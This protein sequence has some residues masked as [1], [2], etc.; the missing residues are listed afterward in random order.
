MSV[1]ARAVRL[2]VACGVAAALAPGVAWAQSRPPL[3]TAG[4]NG[5]ALQ[6]R[7]CSPLPCDGLSVLGTGKT[8]VP[9]TPTWS[10]D[11]RPVAYIRTF[12]GAFCYN[13]RG[14][15]AEWYDR[16]DDGVPPKDLDKNGVPD[17]FDWLL[18][19][20]DAHYLDGW[21][22]IVLLLPAGMVVK[23]EFSSSQWWAMP[24]WKRAGFEAHVK[25]WIAAHPEASV[26]LYLNFMI[27]NPCDL[28]Q[29][30][31]AFRRITQVDP[32]AIGYT[33]ECVPGLVYVHPCYG[34][35]TYRIPDPRVPEDVC[36]FS[37]NIRPWMSVGAREFWFDAA[38]YQTRKQSFVELA[39]SPDY[40]GKAKFGGE[41]VPYKGPGEYDETYVAKTP[42][43]GTTDWIDKQDP[44]GAWT[45]P[46]AKSEVGLGLMRPMEL[47]EMFDAVGRGYV[48]WLYNAA[49]EEGERAK[50][51]Y[52]FGHL[53]DGADF[54]GNGY[55]DAGDRALFTSHWNAYHGLTG[56]RFN[57][58]HGDM[59]DDHKVDD[60]DKTLFNTY[61]T[62]SVESEPVALDLGGPDADAAMP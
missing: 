48:I 4:R 22:R 26:G 20:L 45:F 7:P 51:I 27:N 19:E 2:A 9:S 38:E 15:S 8:W 30:P 54:N 31:N 58:V 32:G 55:P 49:S 10:P 1:C 34:R 6:T 13:S 39:W 52:G 53:I 3:Q 40:L 35:D 33:E 17:A 61:W 62:L 50:R 36:T 11:R 24:A 37:Q 60:T 41:T 28:C 44:D 43:F 14:L 18:A 59:N 25:P 5:P 29:I 47:P 46:I 21:R 16:D 23:Q 42:W 56:R 12:G 57:Y